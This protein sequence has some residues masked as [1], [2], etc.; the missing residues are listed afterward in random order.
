[1]SINATNSSLPIDTGSWLTTGWT[2][3]LPS[4]WTVVK[5]G[6]ALYAT[7]GAVAL[8]CM[9]WEKYS[10]GKAA[11]AEAP[12]KKAQEN[13]Q[14]ILDGLKKE[15]I[16]LCTDPTNND[17]RYQKA[18]A[19]LDSEHADVRRIGTYILSH[20]VAQ[21]KIQKKEYPDILRLAQKDL[22]PPTNVYL[23]ES[24]Y[25]LLATLVKEGYTD[26]YPVAFAAVQSALNLPPPEEHKGEASSEDTDVRI[27]TILSGYHHGVTHQAGRDNENR[28]DRWNHTSII[29]DVC[30]DVLTE[31]VR[32]KFD[33][34]YSLALRAYTHPLRTSNLHL[35]QALVAV[36]YEAAYQP[37]IS[38]MID[39]LN[40]SNRNT[41]WNI[42]FAGIRLCYT[43]VTIEYKPVY[44]VALEAAS[45]GILN[46]GNET[47]AMQSFYMFLS[48]ARRWRDERNI[49]ANESEIYNQ[50]CAMVTVGKRSLYAHSVRRQAETLGQVLAQLKDAG[51]PAAS[52]MLAS[53]SSAQASPF[54]QSIGRA[55]ALEAGP[56]PEERLAAS[57]KHLLDDAPPPS[58]PAAGKTTKRAA[59]KAVKQPSTQLD[60]EV[61][62]EVHEIELLLKHLGKG[63]DAEQMRLVLEHALKTSR[64][65]EGEGLGMQQSPPPLLTASQATYLRVHLSS[66]TQS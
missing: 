63:A 60:L 36:K 38:A 6:G 58:A 19:F 61:Q 18:L 52:S 45:N 44:E 29:H 35:L 43:F 32:Q 2:I 22:S 65:E 10:R 1:M 21:H 9:C 37:A 62:F 59:K 4:L 30:V 28:V 56:G 53:S 66:L 25:N 51:A 12:L 27:S 8:V 55:P 39:A 46:S 24:S 42:H 54:I 11:Q 15:S 34:A 48:F 33:S 3:E 40:A 64:D 26:A 20:L 31:L 7:M 13:A 57:L 50:A 16:S 14:A 49:P 23:R 5:V 41:S 47:I 17:L